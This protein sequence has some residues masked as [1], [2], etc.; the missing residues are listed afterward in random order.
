MEDMK[1][2]QIALIGGLV[3]LLLSIAMARCTHEPKNYVGFVVKKAQTQDAIY[4]SYHIQEPGFLG[5]PLYI[6]D[7]TGKFSIGD[8]LKIAR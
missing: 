3:I 4:S 2:W 8:T 7:T 5:S 6:I 1:E